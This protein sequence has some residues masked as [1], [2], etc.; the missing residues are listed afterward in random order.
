MEMKTPRQVHGGRRAR[1]RAPQRGPCGNATTRPTARLRASTSTLTTRR[2]PR[3]PSPRPTSTDAPMAQGAAHERHITSLN[4]PPTP[5]GRRDA[6]GCTKHNCTGQRRRAAP[7]STGGLRRRAKYGKVSSLDYILR[8]H[9]PNTIPATAPLS[10]T[11][12]PYNYPTLHIHAHH[13]HGPTTD[14]LCRH[15]RTLTWLNL[16]APCVT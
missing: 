6:R 1:R 14:R 12:L 15:S 3:R 9:N 7:Q 8:C 5:T 10:I 11:V 16:T 13:I 2:R 4:T